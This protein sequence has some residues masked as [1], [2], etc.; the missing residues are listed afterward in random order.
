VNPPTGRRMNHGFDESAPVVLRLLTGVDDDVRAALEPGHLLYPMALLGWQHRRLMAEITA[1]WPKQA[2]RRPVRETL[3]W[4]AGELRE[5]GLSD[6]EVAA[7]LGYPRSPDTLR[8][9]RVHEWRDMA[10][11]EQVEVNPEGDAPGRPP[12]PR[13]YGEREEEPAR[14]WVNLPPAAV[15]RAR[16]RDAVAVELRARDALAKQLHR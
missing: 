11:A 2:G 4:W 5:A 12:L 3:G 10:L 8:R 15:A 13:V 16:P 1:V 7:A 14:G 6:D 9:Y